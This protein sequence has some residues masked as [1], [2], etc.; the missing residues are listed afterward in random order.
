MGG[1]GWD[2]SVLV[3]VDGRGLYMEVGGGDDGLCV[4]MII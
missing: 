4:E 3:E 2:G 1:D